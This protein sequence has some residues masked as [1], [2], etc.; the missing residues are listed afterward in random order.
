MPGG[1]TLARAYGLCQRGGCRPGKAKPPPGAN[2]NLCFAF[3]P[4]LP[5]SIP[6]RNSF[7]G[8]PRQRRNQRCLY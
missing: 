3:I 1:A 8:S 6:V 5:I 2:A 4:E 7:R